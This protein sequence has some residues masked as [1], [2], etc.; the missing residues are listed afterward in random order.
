MHDTDLFNSDTPEQDLPPLDIPQHERRVH[1]V[2]QDLPV[3]TLTQRIAR[4][5]MVLQ[6]E[7]QRNFVWNTTKASRL[8]ESLL[9]NIPIP[10]VYV[11]EAGGKQEV[12]DGQ[13]RLT[14]ISAFVNGSFPESSGLR[15]EFKLTGLQVLSELNGERFSWLSAETQNLIL[16]ATLRV[17]MNP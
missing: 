12:V 1:T 17:G 11:A 16:E 14:S 7:F 10:V 2:I 5:A 8:I 9:L 6:P 15:K 13:Q 4:G 3:E